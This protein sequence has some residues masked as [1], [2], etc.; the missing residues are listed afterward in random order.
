MALTDFL[1]MVIVAYQRLPQRVSQGVIPFRA[2]ERRRSRE[3]A[4]Y[5][6]PPVR[7]CP[8]RDCRCVGRGKPEYRSPHAGLMSG[9][10]GLPQLPPGASRREAGPEYVCM[11]RGERNS[12][13]GPEG[14]CG[15]HLQKVR[16]GAF[17]KMRWFGSNHGPWGWRLR[18]FRGDRQLRARRRKPRAL[19]FRYSA[20]GPA[21]LAGAA[22]SPKGPS[23]SDPERVR[24]SF[25]QA[26]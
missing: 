8:V 5:P 22:E 12:S 10:R 14:F 7:L 9:R 21:G 6:V 18:R 1:G 17:A 16:F 23:W 11:R 20:D 15:A 2:G 13:Q 26:S 4:G 25:F 19:G 24:K 3:A